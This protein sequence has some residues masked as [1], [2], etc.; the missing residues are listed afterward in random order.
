MT[1]IIRVAESVL[2]PE[3]TWM[4]YGDL[5]QTEG[6]RVLDVGAG[7]SGLQRGLG[8]RHDYTVVD[9]LVHDSTQAARCFAKDAPRVTLIDSDW[10][11]LNLANRFD[12][13]VSNDLFPNVDQRLIAFLEWSSLMSDRLV[14]SL[15]YF[16]R[17]RA[18][19][20]K[21]LDADEILHV[22]SWSAAQIEA[23]EGTAGWNGLAFP[24]GIE[25]YP[26]SVFENGRNIAVT[27]LSRVVA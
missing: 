12:V 18:Y 7:L 5:F 20:A 6:L 3:V 27:D 1:E 19:A 13:I 17:P 24:D 10:S 11:A 26:Q 25:P 16:L 22:A 4:V 2:L 15:T 23:C 8:E 21:R 9:M 14:I